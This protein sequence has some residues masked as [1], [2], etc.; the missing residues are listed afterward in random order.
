[1]LAALDDS[2]CKVEVGIGRGRQDDDVDFG[3]LE[4][5]VDRGIMLG[6]WVIFRRGVAFGRLALNDG[7]QFQLFCCRH[8]G[9][10]ED[11]CRQSA[12]MSVPRQQLS[13][14]FSPEERGG[15]THIRL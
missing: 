3:I 15:L 8:E 12:V 14:C 4:Y 10:M 9:N 7:V 11:F 5:G 1:M 13:P 6:L 2:L